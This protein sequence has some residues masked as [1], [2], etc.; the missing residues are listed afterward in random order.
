MLESSRGVEHSIQN[1]LL[2]QASP[3]SDEKEWMPKIQVI[4]SFSRLYSEATRVGSTLLHV[5]V[6]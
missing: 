5:V 3:P 1:V 4:H 2:K 6:C